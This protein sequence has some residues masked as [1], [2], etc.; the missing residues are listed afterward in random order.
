MPQISVYVT[1][2]VEKRI[3]REAKLRRKSLS[4][5][6]TEVLSSGAKGGSWDAAFF[7]EVAGCWMG[8]APRV[9][10]EPPEERDSL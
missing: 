7:R 8:R 6:V 9:R 5:Y 2:E 1:K 3:R 10:R 4:A